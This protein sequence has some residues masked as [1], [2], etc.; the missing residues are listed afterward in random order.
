MLHRHHASRQVFGFL[1][2]VLLMGGVFGGVSGIMGHGVFVQSNAFALR[3]MKTMIATERQERLEQ[4][5]MNRRSR[6]SERLKSEMRGM[7]DIGSIVPMQTNTYAFKGKTTWDVA[8]NTSTLVYERLGIAAPI[9]KPSMANWMSRNWRAL[10]Y[11][12]QYL[13]LNGLA[14]YP[15]SPRPGEVGT[16]II[17]GHSSPPTMSAIGSPYEN[18]LSVL[19]NAK[20]GDTITVFDSAGK[21]HRYSVQKTQV[22]PA[23]YTK[24]LL[25]NPHKK[26]IVLFTCYPVGTTRERFVVWAEYEEGDTVATIQK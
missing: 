2:G 15:H 20:I 16:M 9:G 11:Q 12:M 23:T 18:I 21:A 22:V 4:S 17:A 8:L 1:I 6:R 10:E 25:Q 5:I 7:S 14:V 3:G 19:P 24:L 26:E 13:L